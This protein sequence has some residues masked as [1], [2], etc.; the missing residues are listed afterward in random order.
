VT[1][2][3]CRGGQLDSL[4]MTGNMVPTR[5]VKPGETDV[6]FLA[7]SPSAIWFNWMT[8]NGVIVE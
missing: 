6:R 1:L 4:M 2:M 5:N 3:S 7:V 8:G